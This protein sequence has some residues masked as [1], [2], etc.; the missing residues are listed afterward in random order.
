VTLDSAQSHLAGQQ[1]LNQQVPVKQSNEPLTATCTVLHA[2]FHTPGSQQ[3]SCLYL[4]PRKA[5]A[6]CNRCTGG[7][8]RLHT[9][10]SHSSPQLQLHHYEDT[11]P[12]SRGCLSH[13]LVCYAALIQCTAVTDNNEDPQL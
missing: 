2:A 7:S 1:L 6:K 8:I 11:A 5:A 10:S 13:N 4:P 9:G 12:D 3:R